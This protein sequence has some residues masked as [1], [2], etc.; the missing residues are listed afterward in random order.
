[1]TDIFELWVHAFNFT[2]LMYK[3]L[4]NTLIFAVPSL[5]LRN[6]GKSKFVSCFRSNM[7][8]RNTA[9]HK[10]YVCHMNFKLQYLGFPCLRLHLFFRSS[11]CDNDNLLAIF[12]VRKRKMGWWDAGIKRSFDWCHFSK[13]RRKKFIFCRR[14]W[15]SDT[16]EHSARAQLDEWQKNFIEALEILKL[17]SQ[18]R[19]SAG[20]QRYLM[21]ADRYF[22]IRH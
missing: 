13:K 19:E 6:E 18:K 9:S 21:L 11:F 12:S 16:F 3:Y 5:S 14:Y 8:Y 2:L 1:M 10:I 7:I 20:Q 4:S 22:D 15:A 17:L